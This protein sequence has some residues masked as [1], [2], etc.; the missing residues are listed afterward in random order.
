M[1][2][3][4]YNEAKKASNK[5]YMDKLQRVVLWTTPEEKKTIEEKAA[6]AGLSVNQYVKGRALE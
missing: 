2:Y 6:A 5:R 4:G 3:A 1:A